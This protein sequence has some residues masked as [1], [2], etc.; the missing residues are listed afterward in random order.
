MRKGSAVAL[1]IAV[2]VTSLMR[3]GS[4][5]AATC[6]SSVGPGIP[7]PA[8]IAAG[9]GGFHAAWYG[10]SGYMLLCPG[11]ESTATVAYYNTGSRGW[12]AGASGQTAYLGTS[13]PSPG[14]DQP[15]AQKDDENIAQSNNERLDRPH[16]DLIL[17]DRHAGV[18]YLS[19]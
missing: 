6:A 15:S 7:P 4:A 11:A 19:I 18:N 3:G 9:I 10:Q 1:A 13:D 17:A 12:V 5:A 16:R 2:L 14:Q 8:A